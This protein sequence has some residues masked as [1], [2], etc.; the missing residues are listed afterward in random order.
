MF[1]TVPRM[2]SYRLQQQPPQQQEE[3]PEGGMGDSN[4]GVRSLGSEAD[5]GGSSVLGLKPDSKPTPDSES[6]SYSDVNPDTDPDNDREGRTTELNESV[7]T[8]PDDSGDLGRAGVNTL[9]PTEDRTEG[10]T[11]TTD[12]SSL[13]LPRLLSTSATQP[14]PSPSSPL[15]PRNAAHEHDGEHHNQP[16]PEPEPEAG[17]GTEIE[18]ETAPLSLSH[19][20]LFE[21][22]D[23]LSEPSSPASFASMPTSYSYMS[24]LSRE[25]SLAGV[26]RSPDR[27]GAGGMGIGMGMGMVGSEELVMPLLNVSQSTDSRWTTT[28][29]TASTTRNLGQDKG[30]KIVILGNTVRKE[31]FI[32]ELKDVKEVIELK[33]GEYGIIGGDRVI[34]TLSTGLTSEDVRSNLL[35]NLLETCCLVGSGT[36]TD[37]VGGEPDRSCVYCA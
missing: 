28:T 35:L 7:A 33:Q 34:A 1:A 25:S 18:T 24:S 36:S 6:D 31:E 11:P 16:E 3:K 26:N 13:P 4:Y 37:I 14:P 19:A 9:S 2:R 8:P 20:Y 21:E 12:P 32:R 17:T 30:I 10:L 29:A 15:G 22:R 5:W 23:N 27:G